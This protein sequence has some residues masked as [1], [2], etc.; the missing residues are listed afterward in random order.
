MCDESFKH[1]KFFRSIR[2]GSW[3]NDVLLQVADLFAFEAYKDAAGREKQD[4]P[5]PSMRALL[6]L[7]SVGIRTQRMPREA[8]AEM[9]RRVDARKSTGAPAQQVNSWE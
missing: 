8:I 1:K 2:E 3:E 4:K 7:D 6:D 5:R 9:K